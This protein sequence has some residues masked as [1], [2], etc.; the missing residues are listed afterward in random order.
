MA[1]KKIEDVIAQYLGMGD[2]A[3]MRDDPG[4]EYISTERQIHRVGPDNRDATRHLNIELTDGSL[5]VGVSEGYRDLN[6]NDFIGSD[7]FD[8]R[9]GLPYYDPDK[10]EY[11]SFDLMSQS[12]NV[13]EVDMMELY[14]GEALALQRKAETGEASAEELGLLD[15]YNEFLRTRTG[16]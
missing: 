15:A 3:R 2:I 16:M 8:N 1:E 5:P 7:G 11:V 14:M 13:P 9:P 4:R 6:Y 10:E 12:G